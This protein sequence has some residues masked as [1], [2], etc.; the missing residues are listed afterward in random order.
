M[1]S[2]VL[3][4]TSLN[5]LT[6]APGIPIIEMM[7]AGVVVVTTPAEVTGTDLIMEI[8]VNIHQHQSVDGKL[9]VVAVDMAMQQTVHMPVEVA[10]QTDPGARNSERNQTGNLVCYVQIVHT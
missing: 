5:N 8:P 1:L 3:L 2:F 7:E 6:K 9:V 10:A 4:L